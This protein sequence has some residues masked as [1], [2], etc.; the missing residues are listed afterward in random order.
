MPAVSQEPATLSKLMDVISCSCKAED[1]AC[2]G[3]VD[4]VS[5]KEMTFVINDLST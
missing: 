3:G 1:K 5:V 2:I 4:T